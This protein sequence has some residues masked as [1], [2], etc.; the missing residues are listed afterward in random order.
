M[1]RFGREVDIY[2]EYLDLAR[3]PGLEH[4]RRTAAYLA[5]K[6]SQ[7]GPDLVIGLDVE[8]LR[9]ATDNR[10]AFGPR[11]PLVYCCA[12][13]ATV[14]A[15]NVPRDVVGIVSEY[16]LRRT[17]AL[18]RRL[19]PNARKL[20]VVVG[21]SETDRRWQQRARD[22]LGDHT[23]AI[24]T[25]FL[26][27]MERTPLLDAVSKMPRDTII[28]VL[29]YFED[30]A[31]RRFIPRD[32]IEEIARAASAPVYGPFYTTMGYG[33]LGGHMDSFEGIGEAAADLAI[34]IL[35]GRDPA[36]LPSQSKV[37]HRF[38]VDARQLQRWGMSRA[39]LPSGT[40]V[41]FKGLSL[42]EQHQWQ[43]VLV[44]VG[45]LGQSLLIAGLFH[46][47]RR[48][49]LA[50]IE[51][52]HRMVELA[53][54]NRSV[55]AG[56][57]TASIAHE[58]NQPLAAIVTS[59]NAGLRWLA[60][61]TPNLEAAVAAFR[62]IV[63]DGHRA[64]RLI[65]TVRAMFKKDAQEKV[66][67]DINELLDEVLGLMRFELDRQQVSA[68]RVLTDGLPHVLADRIQLQQVVLNLM[69]NA[70]EAMSSVPGGA[71]LL[72]VR[73]EPNEA[74]DVIVAIKDSGP[75]IDP[76]SINRIFEP[77]YTTKANGMGMGL[78][79]C[80]SI[81]EAHDGRLSVA[82]G[83]PC[84]SVFQIV[85][86]RTGGLRGREAASRCDET[87]AGAPL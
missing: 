14:A 9:F 53:H 12:S 68:T 23:A 24:E 79:I 19:Q 35:D 45:L 31:G 15:I 17:F 41:L 32:I 66:L 55:T 34:Q 44:A 61:R 40:L 62:R 48:R 27:G 28:L 3:F 50:E 59:G 57:M 56:E 60:N 64:S 71:R 85:L 11:I 39:S 80:R 16:D 74:G 83:K 4:R 8:A 67:L 77:F 84:G 22:Q 7:T 1:Q 81:V 58:I 25:T 33:V 2:S 78:P 63:A 49:R 29:T 70:V 72:Q 76:D 87:R 54:M 26:V 5:A 21:A 47:R 73:S 6:Y 46:Q 65:E 38:V 69:L 82:P 18:A 43:I 20:V 75:G 36:S 37:E 42:W 52:R 86:P 30:G 51:A 13:P 10:E